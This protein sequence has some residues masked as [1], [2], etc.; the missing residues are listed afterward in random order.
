VLDHYED[1]LPGDPEA[2]A[3]WERAQRP[4][5]RRAG[6]LLAAELPADAPVLDV[7]CGFGFLPAECDRRGLR[8]TGLEISPTGIAH[9]RG[10]GVDVREGT[11]SSATFDEGAFAAVSAFYVIEHLDD[12]GEFLREVRRVLRRDGLLLLRWPQSAPLV[13]W[14][15][16]LGV[17]LDLFDA[18]S[19]LTDFTPDSLHAL[20]RRSGFEVRWTRPGGSTRPGAWVPRIAGV[21]GAVVG[22]FLYAA[23]LGKF[24]APGASK[25]T[26]ARAV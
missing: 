17:R 4:L 6:N 7:G 9:A 2:I 18:P 19:H 25:T 3:A 8:A 16:L 15:R 10:L 20:L 23:S 13:R 5:V 24:V 1:Y 12:P 14:C 22:D 11:L 21:L 26:L